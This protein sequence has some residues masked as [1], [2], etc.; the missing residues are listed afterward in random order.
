MQPGMQ[1]RSRWM[2]ELWNERGLSQEKVLKGLVPS[3]VK[4]VFV[5]GIN[6]DTE[7]HH[8]RDYF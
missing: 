5:G 6:K 1:A 2:E 4:K 8:L 7:E 3:A